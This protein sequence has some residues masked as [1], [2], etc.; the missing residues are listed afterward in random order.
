MFPDVTT[1]DVVDIVDFVE[2]DRSWSFSIHFEGEWRVF[3]FAVGERVGEF[4]WSYLRTSASG[5]S[6]MS[7]VMMPKKCP[8]IYC[9][10]RGV[11][12]WR[13]PLSGRVD[14]LLALGD[15]VFDPTQREM[16][17]SRCAP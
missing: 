8:G 1:V 15:K 13:A 3:D 12:Y 6:V 2:D 5:L 14:H 9:A 17:L 7:P 10:G 4:Q 11:S 16:Y